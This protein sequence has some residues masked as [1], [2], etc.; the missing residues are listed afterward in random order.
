VKKIV[1]LSCVVLLAASLLLAAGCGQGPLQV[2]T[3]TQVTEDFINA[4]EK[5][6]LDTAYD[7]LTAE[8]KKTI[9][10][11]EWRKEA[12]KELGPIPGNEPVSYRVMDEKI[13]DK[14]AVVGV[15]LSQGGQ[16]E[17][18]YVA[19]SK[20]GGTWKVSLGRSNTMNN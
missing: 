15:Q 12:T 10:R 6:D 5:D 8:D 16:S 14:E 1:L 13:K 17:S 7:S 20:E 4:L 19:L 9:S 2:K 11:A 3:P 18:V